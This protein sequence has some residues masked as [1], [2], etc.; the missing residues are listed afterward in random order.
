MTVGEG[1]QEVTLSVA[2]LNQEKLPSSQALSIICWKEKVFLLS[3]NFKPEQGT[4]IYIQLLAQ[5]EESIMYTVDISVRQREEDG[6]EAHMFRSK[7]SQSVISCRWP[8]ASPGRFEVPG[9]FQT[10]RDS[11]APKMAEPA[12]GIHG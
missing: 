2:F 10:G 6:D 8:M 4:N 7:A 5:K 1:L 9:H 3:V 12:H 11:T